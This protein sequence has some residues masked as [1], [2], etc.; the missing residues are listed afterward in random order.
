MRQA[1]LKEMVM[2]T[3]SGVQ[4]VGEDKF[5]LDAENG[6]RLHSAV[7][8]AGLLGLRAVTGAALQAAIV[9]LQ[10]SGLADLHMRS[11]Y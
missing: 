11:Y 10:G 1:Y 7:L 2:K 4:F 5:E 3:Q 9:L 8:L 6:L